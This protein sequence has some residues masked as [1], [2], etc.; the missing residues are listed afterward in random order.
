MICIAACIPD[1]CLSLL[2]A[3]DECLAHQPYHAQRYSGHSLPSSS[4]TLLM[5]LCNAM[6]RD[7]T[8]QYPVKLRCGAKSRVASMND[9]SCECLPHAKY[10]EAFS[11]LLLFRSTMK[12]VILTSI[13]CLLVDG[14]VI[15]PIHRKLPQMFAN[16]PL[17]ND[18]GA[19]KY[20]IY[21]LFYQ[22]LDLQV[23][24]QKY[25]QQ[26]EM[27][28]NFATKIDE[29]R[30]ETTKALNKLD[31]ARQETIKSSKET[32]NAFDRLV[33]AQ[34]E[35]NKLD[36]MLSSTKDQLK[37]SNSMYLK[38][39][40]QLNARGAL[41]F[42]RA[43]IKLSLPRQDIDPI[44]KMKFSEPIDET[45]KL[46]TDD[47]EFKQTM[48]KVCSRKKMAPNYLDKVIS[49]LWSASSVPMHGRQNDP[50]SVV[51]RSNDWDSNQCLGL[52]ILFEH[53]SIPY[54]YEKED[55]EIVDYFPAEE[56]SP[57]S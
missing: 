22:K 52:V 6:I 31:E 11:L 50:N 43:Y 3:Q 29:A 21:S 13:L 54:C 26:V 47:V 15:Q 45:L 8:R 39:R 24:L 20:G 55:G 4:I 35:I 30:Q 5:L 10:V 40:S 48:S 38:I 28:L 27:N 42:I 51:I 46:L 57:S 2:G 19:D 33:E 25:L 12:C 18:D 36:K 44:A 56:D 9:D 7:R 49:S 32:T 53:F 17:A 37:N 14:F 34:S 23:T 41:E 16:I 1:E